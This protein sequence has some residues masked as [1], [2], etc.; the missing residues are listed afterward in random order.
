MLKSTIKDR[1]ATILLARPEARNA[2]DAGFWRD[3][4]A[5]IRQLDADPAV[6]VIVIAGEGPHFCSG[7]DLAYLT[8]LMTQADDPARANEH[9][10]RNII[11]LQLA[12]D[13]LNS[14]RKPVLTVIHGACMG[15]GLDLIAAA[16]MRYAAKDAFFQIHEINIGI[17]ADLGSLQRLR[18]Q[19]PDGILRELAFSGRRMSAEEAYH[20]GFVTGLLPDAASALDHALSVAREIAEKSPLAVAGTKAVLNHARDHSVAAG[21]DYV[22]TWNAGMLSFKDAAKGAEASLGRSTA[23]FSDLL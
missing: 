11:E 1:V 9:M 16:D 15:G 13:V 23:K 22:A 4:P 5:L 6:R 20:L 2:L 17:V 12:F 18:H 14:I 7:I 19:L 10:R 21:L 8:S 3:F